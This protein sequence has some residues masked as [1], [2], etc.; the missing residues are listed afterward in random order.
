ME[1]FKWDKYY[2]LILASNSINLPMFTPLNIYKHRLSKGSWKDMEKN[3][4]YS[5]RG[6]IFLL[7]NET[8]IFADAIYYGDYLDWCRCVAE[9]QQAQAQNCS[10]NRNLV[11]ETLVIKF[12]Q[13]N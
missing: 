3:G 5:L 2:P 4:Q 8:S 7:T 1:V 6:L 10:E 9:L 13:H 12:I 11:A